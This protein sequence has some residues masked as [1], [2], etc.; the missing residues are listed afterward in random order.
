MYLIS[1]I[2][3]TY[4][5]EKYIERTIKSLINQN[6]G[7]ENLELILVDDC[8]TDS[9]RDI[10]KRYSDKFENINHYF[11]KDNHGF[12]GHGRNLGIKNSKSKYI[13]FID[14]DDEYEPT[15][16]EIMY[17]TIDLNNID[18]VSTNFKIIRKDYVENNT[19]FENIINNET[20][21]I[22]SKND[23]SCIVSLDKFYY[24]RDTEVWNKI[25]KK[26]IIE[27]ND[28]KFIENAL[29]E[30]TLFLYNYYEYADK[31]MYIDYYGYKWY[32]DGENL[33]YHSTNATL[34]FIYSFYDILEFTK[35][36]NQKIDLN[37]LFSFHI[38]ES[39]I[40]CLFIPTNDIKFVLEKLYEFEKLIDFSG[41]LNYFW[42]KVINKFVIKHQLKIAK[43]LL[44]IIRE[45]RNFYKKIF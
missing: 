2:C 26:E 37:R 43:T 36:S 23:A 9:T 8:S 16:C 11:L 10:I 15:Y 35:K 27:K 12:P 41:E 1:I 17:N 39:L 40:N 18:V 28:V 29:N 19:V 33:S 30:D 24:L 14:N 34:K 20:I 42:N 13:M 44:I 31:L 6:I 7:F 32:R 4:N 21:N 45:G 5:C 38:E 22:I 25:F 3:P